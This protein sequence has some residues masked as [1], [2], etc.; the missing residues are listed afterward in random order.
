VE[1][2]HSE[3]RGTDPEWIVAEVLP[4]ESADALP[5]YMTLAQRCRSQKGR[6]VGILRSRAGWQGSYEERVSTE[7]GKSHDGGACIAARE[8]L[9]EWLRVRTETIKGRDIDEHEL[10]LTIDAGTRHGRRLPAVRLEGCVEE[11][12][13][14][15]I[16][17]ARLDGP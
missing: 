15:P 1:P 4:D 8:L 17:E 12:L 11:K 9:T 3:A 16:A 2:G 10:E 5:Q 14:K 7:I 6:Q 13:Q